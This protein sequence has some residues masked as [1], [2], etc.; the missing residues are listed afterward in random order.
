MEITIIFAIL[1]I[2]WIAD[3][4]LQ[5][6]SQAKG[7]SKKWKPLLQYTINYSLVWFLIVGLFLGLE[8]AI[9]FT[10]ITFVAHTITDYF[11]SRLNSRLWAQ[12][13]T[14][15]FFV[16]VG[17]DQ[18]LHYVQLFLTYLLISA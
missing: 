16:A 12:G 9:I 6:D 10:S 15:D 7:K 17:F 5:T 18:I 8:K 14:H 1:I 11:T 13:R 2:H 4:I 3:F